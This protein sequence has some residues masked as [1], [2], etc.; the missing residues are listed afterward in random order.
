MELR[1]IYWGNTYIYHMEFRNE[2]TQQP[3][4]LAG[5]TITFTLKRRLEDPD[6][7][8]LIQVNTGVLPDNPDT[9]AGKASLT[10]SSDITRVDYGPYAYDFQLKFP[11]T[12][13]KVTTLRVGK[14]KVAQVATHG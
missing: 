13:E 8:A 9:Q 4:P 12:P 11:G 3:L 10:L 2:K 1:D 6:N 5:G 7:Q 14:V